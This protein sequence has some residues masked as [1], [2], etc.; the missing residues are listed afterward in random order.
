VVVVEGG[1]RLAER[2]R[3]GPTPVVARVADG[4]LV[5]DVRTV[6]DG[7]IAAL[8]LAVAEAARA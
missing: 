4:A 8:V 1:D 6:A 7:E 2:L 3:T 5:L